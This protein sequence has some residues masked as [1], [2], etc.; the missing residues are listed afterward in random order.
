MLANAV[1]ERIEHYATRV[2]NPCPRGRENAS[3][4]KHGVTT[5][6][7]GRRSRTGSQPGVMEGNPLRGQ[8]VSERLK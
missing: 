7:D 4:T 2:V 5:N 8:V 3:W 1:L 6:F